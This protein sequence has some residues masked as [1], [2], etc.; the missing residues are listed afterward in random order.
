MRKQSAADSEDNLSPAMDL[1]VTTSLLDK[2]LSAQGFPKLSKL[3]KPVKKQKQKAIKVDDE[4][5]SDA[6]EDD[7]DADADVNPSTFAFSQEPREPQVFFYGER[8]TE[9]KC[10][11]FWS[12]GQD[13]SICSCK[14]RFNMH[15]NSF[16]GT[17]AEVA[18][19]C[20]SLRTKVNPNAMPVTHRPGL[21]LAPSEDLWHARFGSGMLLQ[22]HGGDN[23]VK[24]DT[25]RSQQLHTTAVQETTP[26]A[27]VTSAG[28][29][30]G[31]S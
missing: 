9:C 23:N 21:A 16:A 28:D 11:F 8:C 13:S 4:I 6:V 27:S 15:V 14:H 2:A 7:M 24:A 25:P 26:S 20:K 1:D 19:S 31:C 22:G 18:S 10:T 30:G 17:Q 3:I 5:E 29:I 12:C